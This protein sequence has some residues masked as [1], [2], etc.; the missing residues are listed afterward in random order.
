VAFFISYIYKKEEWGFFK[1]FFSKEKLD[2]GT[3]ADQAIAYRQNWES[4]R[5]KKHG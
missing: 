5:W 3:R 1:R 4:S 2:K